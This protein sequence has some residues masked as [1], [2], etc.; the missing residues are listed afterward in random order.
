MT[1]TYNPNIYNERR[2]SGRYRRRITIQCYESIVDEEGIAI[3]D[4]VPVATIWSARK[5][6]TTRWREYFRAAGLNAE[7]MFQYEIRYREGITENMRIV[8]GKRVVNDQEVDRVLEI[9][10]VLD[11][12]KGDRTETWIMALE[13]TP[14]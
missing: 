7:K 9:K 14:G 6:L 12:A 3:H 5:P 10:A 2:N 8:D 4:W 1:M 13:L 11:D